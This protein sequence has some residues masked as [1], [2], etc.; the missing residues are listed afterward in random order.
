MDFTRS[1]ETHSLSEVAV[2]YMKNK[3]LSGEFKS[4]DKLIE[5]NISADLAISRPPVREALRE[6]SVQGMIVFS[7]RKGNYVLDMSLE[8]ILEIFDIRISLEV[9]V[10]ELLV[11]KNLLTDE[12]F[13][14]LQALVAK[15]REQS[16]KELSQHERIYQLNVLDLEFHSYLWTASKSLR[17]GKIMESLFFQLLIAMNRNPESLGS[18]EEKAAEHQGIL[19][20]LQKNDLDLAISQFQTHLDRYVQELLGTSSSLTTSPKS[21]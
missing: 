21:R 5:S 14:H 8:E 10:L 2:L 3:I 18:F 19:D 16:Q 13:C 9:K 7:P 17:R 6:L 1:Y 12:D 4:G 11:G 20:A 15:M